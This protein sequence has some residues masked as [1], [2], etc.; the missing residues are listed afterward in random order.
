VDV[1]IISGHDYSR[2]VKGVGVSGAVNFVKKG[3][4]PDHPHFKGHLTDS[5]IQRSRNHFTLPV[6]DP[7]LQWYFAAP[8]LKELRLQFVMEFKENKD[9][10]NE[11]LMKYSDNLNN[12]KGITALNTLTLEQ[13]LEQHLFREIFTKPPHV[14]SLLQHI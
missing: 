2:G 10:V 7:P 13:F 12:L 1:A 3:F 11:D 14:P 6:I 9:E 8:S 4:Y 5:T